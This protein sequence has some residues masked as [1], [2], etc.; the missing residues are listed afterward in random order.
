MKTSA[1]IR[2]SIFTLL[3]L[4]FALPAA[5]DDSFCKSQPLLLIAEEAEYTN[6]KGWFIQRENNA[7][8]LESTWIEVDDA[9]LAQ[10]KGRA[11]ENGIQPGDVARVGGII[12][13]DEVEDKY[14]AGFNQQSEGSLSVISR[15]GR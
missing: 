7:L 5:A 3:L 9:S 2:H 14:M 13:W 8:F 10:V 6:V 11:I 15:Q 12:L 1:M 4:I